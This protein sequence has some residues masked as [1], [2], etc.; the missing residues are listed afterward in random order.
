ML[1]YASSDVFGE[2]MRMR[3]LVKILAACVYHIYAEVSYAGQST[4]KPVISSHS[5]INKT[6]ILTTNGSLMKVL[7]AFCNTFGMH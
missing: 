7:G 3:S 5:K 6:K 2:T 1:I 4:V